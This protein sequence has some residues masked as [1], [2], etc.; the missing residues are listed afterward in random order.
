MLVPLWFFVLSIAVLAWQGF[1]LLM[2]L[3]APLMRYRVERFEAPA[4]DSE[5]FLRTLEALTDAQ[6]NHHS[7][8][9]VLTDGEEFYGAELHAIRAATRSINLEAYIFQRGKIASEFIAALAERAQAGVKV[10]LVL[11]AIGS[12]STSQGYCRELIESGGRISFYHP[13]SWRSVASINNRTHREL[14]VVDGTCGFIGGAGIADH[15]LVDRRGRRH[16]RDTVIRVEGDIVSNLQAT[17]AENWL[18]TTGEVIFGE[19]YFPE[20]KEAGSAKAMVINSSPS[21]GGST[22]ARILYQALVSAARSNIRITTPY[23]LP[24]SSMLRE[25]VRAAQ[26]GVKIEIIVPGKKS[27]HGLTRSSSRRL[28]GKL[29]EAGVRIYEY[30]PAMIHAKVMVIDDFWSVTGS[31]NFDNRS[32]GLNDEVNLAASDRQLAAQLT[33]DFAA[34]I[35]ASREVTLQDWKRRS[36][37]ERLHEALGWA[38]QRQQ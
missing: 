24:D 32:F 21:A 2:A 15:W 33:R 3:F 17:F 13:F 4:I 19:E 9:T 8:L 16:W 6:V 20:L 11:D 27:D 34:D 31:T 26:S 12:F 25:L 22:R 10:N 23:F 35:A 38:V 30:Q 1:L 28:Y 29:L 5:R 7:S 18:E 14:L 37:V 36:L